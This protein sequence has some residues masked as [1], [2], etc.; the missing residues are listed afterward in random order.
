MSEKRLSMS[1]IELAYLY[2][3]CHFEFGLGDGFASLISNQI[4]NFILPFLNIFHDL[5]D[6]QLPIFGLSFGLNEEPIF[7]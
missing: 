1:T 4:G 7:G 5:L 3:L 2:C 6:H